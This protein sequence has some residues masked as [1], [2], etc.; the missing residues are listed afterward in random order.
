M[1]G[2]GHRFLG[3]LEAAVQ[4]IERA[5]RRWPVY[6]GDVRRYLLSTFPYGIYYRHEAKTLEI[7]VVKDQRRDP[8]YGR[9][10]LR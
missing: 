2:L 6:E 7:L 8:N 4:E 10:R 3:E 1:S 9:D 5:P